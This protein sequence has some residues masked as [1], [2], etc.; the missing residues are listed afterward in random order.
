MCATVL[1]TREQLNTQTH[2]KSEMISRVSF[3][4]HL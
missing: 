1:N 4:H 3:H 2:S